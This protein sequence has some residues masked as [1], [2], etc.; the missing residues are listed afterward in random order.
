MRTSSAALFLSLAACGPGE[1]NQ[2]VPP[3]A[4]TPAQD[5]ER[6]ECALDRSPEFK[7][8][9]SLERTAT[10]E[11]AVLTVRQPDGGF[12]RLRVLKDGRGLEAADGS[13]PAK[14]TVT[15]AETI[16]VVI[17]DARYRLPARVGPLPPQ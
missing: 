2:A 10:A 11:G 3:N 12:H 15:G 14:V 8:A 13:Q 16:E 6:V 5:A 9:C 1:Q 7:R 17:G 4:A